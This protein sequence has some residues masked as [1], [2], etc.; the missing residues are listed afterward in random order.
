MLNFF[1]LAKSLI[2]VVKAKNETDDNVKTADR[3]VF[4]NMEKKIRDIDETVAKDNTR[5]RADIYEEMRKRMEEVRV[6]NEADPEIET[7]DNSVFAD[8][9]KQIEE[10]QR[11]IEAQEG[12][13]MGAEEHMCFIVMQ[14]VP[15]L[16]QVLLK[17]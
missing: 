6:E 9:Q 3:T 2:D 1:N 8:M 12:G 17:K 5:S 13:N 11:K 4:E 10:L 16:H 14:G 15:L 7:A